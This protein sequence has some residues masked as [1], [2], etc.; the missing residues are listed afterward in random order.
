MY[1]HLCF[2]GL[3]LV[4]TVVSRVAA[5]GD[6]AALTVDQRVKAEEAIE[7][8]YWSHRI[9]PKDNPG[10]KPDFKAVMPE[11]L[12]RERVENV[13]KGS[14]ALEQFWNQP[15]TPEQLQAELGRIAR[16]TRR[17]AV[18]EEIFRSLGD[19]PTVIAETLA[20]SSLTRAA[21]PSTRNMD[22]S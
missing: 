21:A 5:T 2:V 11:S 3:A 8:V 15:V 10:P 1:R 4:T 6:I 13:L 22:S 14:A 18:L 20:R 17:P 16:D 9:W 12:L 19:D 7:R